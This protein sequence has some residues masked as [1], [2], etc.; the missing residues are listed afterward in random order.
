MGAIS[1]ARD[2]EATLQTQ[3]LEMAAFTRVSTHPVPIV[4]LVFRRL[5]FLIDRQDPAECLLKL[6]RLIPQN[7]LLSFGAL[8]ARVLN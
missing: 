3:V 8:G 7:A 1:L 2:C 6:R 5:L 4:F